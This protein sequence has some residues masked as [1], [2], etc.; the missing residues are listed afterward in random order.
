VKAIAVLDARGIQKKSRK[1]K[2]SLALPNAISKM[3]TGEANK[4]P[5]REVGEK[6]TERERI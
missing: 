1:V 4:K 2:I 5:A 6:T 3:A